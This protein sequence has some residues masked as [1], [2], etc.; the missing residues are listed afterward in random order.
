MVLGNRNW[1]PKGRA[2]QINEGSFQNK[3]YK[4]NFKKI[5]FFIVGNKRRSPPWRGKKRNELHFYSFE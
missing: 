3:S 2:T 4:V 5:S 1:G